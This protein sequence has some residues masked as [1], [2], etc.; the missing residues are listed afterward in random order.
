MRKF[1][2]NN[3]VSYWD[4]EYNTFVHEFSTKKFEDLAEYFDD[5]KINNLTNIIERLVPL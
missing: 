1:F 3:K 5:Y 2:Y 4:S